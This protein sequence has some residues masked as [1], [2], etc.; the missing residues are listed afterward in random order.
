MN[1]LK[2][3]LIIEISYK[4]ITITHHNQNKKALSVMW[5]TAR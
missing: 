4:K 3:R 5:C 1:I 2:Q